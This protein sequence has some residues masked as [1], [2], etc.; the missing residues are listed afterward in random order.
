MY[1]SDAFLLGEIESAELDRATWQ[2]TNFYV[3]LND[4]A[5]ALLGFKRPFMGKIM[6]CI[7]VNLI[8]SI[9]DTAILDRTRGELGDLRQCKE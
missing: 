7:P 5:T 8:K 3:S 4:E 6:V 9:E 2:I 1:T